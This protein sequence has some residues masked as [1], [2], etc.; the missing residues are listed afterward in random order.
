MSHHYSL[1]P[2][3]SNT[4]P[5]PTPTA[6]APPSTPGSLST[7]GRSSTSMSSASFSKGS[8]IGSKRESTDSKASAWSRKE[9]M[10]A[11]LPGGITIGGRGMWCFILSASVSL[12]LRLLLY[13]ACN[14]LTELACSIPVSP[15]LHFYS[16]APIDSIQSFRRP[17]NT[18]IPVITQP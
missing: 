3:T 15:C 8:A 16:S 10:E 17:A 12:P 4:G 5:P 13:L 1:Y 18:P 7:K 14:Q 2:T 9:W 11:P 6:M